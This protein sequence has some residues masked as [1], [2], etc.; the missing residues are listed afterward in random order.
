M[1]TEKECVR[2]NSHTESGVCRIQTEYFWPSFYKIMAMLPMRKNSIILNSLLDKQFILTV[3][4]IP[5]SHQ[6]ADV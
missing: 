6:C 3:K 1:G 5:K 4:S 2:D